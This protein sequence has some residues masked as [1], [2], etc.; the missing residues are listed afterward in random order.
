MARSQEEKTRRRAIVRELRE[1][2]R[3]EAESRMPIS[4]ADL[5]DLFA[6]LDSTLFERRG[7]KI[8]CYCDRTLRRTRE[9]LR[10]RSLA[11]NT[12]AEWLGA[13]GGYCDCQVAANVTQSWAEHVGYV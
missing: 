8:W 3:A 9:F 12:I 13:Y 4:K 1:K 2:D 10:S 6:L 5:K 7:D 11:E